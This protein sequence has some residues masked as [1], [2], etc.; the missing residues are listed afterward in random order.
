MSTKSE[1]MPKTFQQYLSEFTG[2]L[3]LE[4]D[5]QLA[6]HLGVT[7]GYIWKVRH[8]AR[9]TDELCLEMARVLQVEPGLILIARNAAKEPG[10]VG[11]AWKSILGRVAVVSSLLIAT[12][13]IKEVEL[14]N[15]GVGGISL[16]NQQLTPVLK[17]T[18]ISKI[19]KW[20]KVVTKLFLSLFPVIHASKTQHRTPYPCPAIQS[21]R[22]S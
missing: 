10:A 17:I 4:N 22:T 8:E 13:A 16:Q 3:G 6:H 15:V 11:D 12:H 14:S 1:N 19:T 5:N 20:I 18:G 9:A 2:R 21:T 7:R